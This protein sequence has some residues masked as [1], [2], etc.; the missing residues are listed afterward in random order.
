MEWAG[1]VLVNTSG[2]ILLNLRDDSA[3]DYWPNCWDVIGGVVEDDETPDECL[4]REM[5]EETGEALTSF[6]PFNVYD[7]PLP[8]GGVAKFHVYCGRLN[9]PASELVLGEGQEHRFFPI[10]QLDALNLASGTDLVLRDFVASA[11]YEAL[12][13]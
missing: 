6:D 3:A 10:S 9:K 5:R 12:R 1:I 8:N 2:E 7:V 4:V 11:S 13:R